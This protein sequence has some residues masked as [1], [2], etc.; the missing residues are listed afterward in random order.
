MFGILLSTAFSQIGNVASKPYMNGGFL[1]DPGGFEMGMFFVPLNKKI[2]VMKFYGGY[3]WFGG[4]DG[5]GSYED[6]TSVFG[7][8][9]T[10]NDRYDGE[11]SISN[12]WGFGGYFFTSFDNTNKTFFLSQL[13]LISYSESFYNKYYDSSEILGNN[14]KYYS[15]SKTPSKDSMGFEVGTNIFISLSE[16]PNYSGLYS[17]YGYFGLSF[18]TIGSL[19]FRVGAAATIF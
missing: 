10:F 13:G 17:F 8:V 4:H 19:I 9:N 5:S 3:G 15:E 1:L 2:T 12:Y 11:F 7:T 6:Y 18:S 14:G 16:K